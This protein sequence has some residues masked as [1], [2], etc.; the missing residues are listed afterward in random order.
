MRRQL[1]NLYLLT[2]SFYI[3]AFTVRALGFKRKVFPTKKLLKCCNIL[4]V[5]LLF[6]HVAMRC[7]QHVQFMELHALCK[8][9]SIFRS[10]CNNYKFIILLPR[11]PRDQSHC[12]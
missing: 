4:L 8:L 7:C 6:E 10:H 9:D 2:F 12:E 1:F 5:C 11:R 3:D